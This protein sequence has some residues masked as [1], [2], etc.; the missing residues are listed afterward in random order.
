MKLKG[1]DR[2][3]QRKT[4]PNSTLSITNPI[5]TDPG[6]NPG[7]RGERPATNSLSHGTAPLC[8]LVDAYERFGG[9]LSLQCR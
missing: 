3:A 5:W 1:E 8:S 4:C 7:L 2:S 9:R 6:L